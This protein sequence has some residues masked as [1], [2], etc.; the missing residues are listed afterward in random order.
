MTE[1]KLK[2]RQNKFRHPSRLHTLAIATAMPRLRANKRN[3]LQAESHR[4]VRMGDALLEI[5]RN[6]QLTDQ[7]VY[8]LTH[9]REIMAGAK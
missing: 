9:I 5:G 1:S 8:E 7:E 4:P 6:M 3:K 2:N